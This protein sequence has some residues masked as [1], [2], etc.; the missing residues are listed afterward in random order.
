MERE[1]T[2]YRREIEKRNSEEKKEGREREREAFTPRLKLDGG[3]E[4]V[5]ISF[6]WP[7]FIRR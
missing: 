6:V 1:R 2:C 3:G 4:G 7:G 5:C